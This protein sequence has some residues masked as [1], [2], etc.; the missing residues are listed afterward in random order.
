MRK[1]CVIAI[2]FVATGLFAGACAKTRV[3]RVETRP[4]VS[5]VKIDQRGY[6]KKVALVLANRVQTPAGRGH[7]ERFVRQLA[8]TVRAEVDHVRLV[9]EGDTD[10]PP[11]SRAWADY[12]RPV[13]VQDV[14]RVARQAGYQTLLRANLLAVQPSSQK[15]GFWLLRRERF[16]VTVKVILDV[17]DPFTAAKMASIVK[18][19]KVK[20]DELDYESYQA[21]ELTTVEALDEA[22]D[23]MADELGGE[24]GRLIEETPWRCA[25]VTVRDKHLILGAGAPE[26]VKVGDRL[27][28]FEGRRQLKSKNG[29]AFTVPGFKLGEIVIV[30]VNGPTSE[31]EMAAPLTIQ[32]DDFALPTR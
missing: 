9:T 32:P 23:D 17:L 28:V 19:R 22:I 15:E 11:F 5:E 18:E 2:L 21:G 13:V 4:T 12:V 31:A 16:Y 26:G 6:M 14:A 8:D 20:L 27:S 1:F 24:A 3:Q 7:G 30:S 29:E 25:I 10:F